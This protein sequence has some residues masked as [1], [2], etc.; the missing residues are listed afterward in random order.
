MPNLAFGFQ[1]DLG[2]RFGDVLPV[3]I[4]GEAL[5]GG[6]GTF[7]GGIGVVE[8]TPHGGGQPT[9]VAGLE[10]QAGH[11][12]DDGFTQTACGGRDQR[13]ARS[14]GLERDDAERFVPTGQDDGVGSV[15]PAE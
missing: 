8:N 3:E 7:L 12:V 6:H 5:A 4:D 1:I 9:D 13:G 10:G 14:G 11:A 2:R 15:Q